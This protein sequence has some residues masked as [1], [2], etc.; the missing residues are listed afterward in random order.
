MIITTIGEV[1]KMLS[2]EVI[3][4]EDL[5]KKIK[6]VSIDSRK[7]EEGMIYV[8]LKGNR[9]DGHDFIDSVKEK[10]AALSL[11]DKENV[12]YPTGIPL[13]LVENT[14]E[15]LQKL[16]KEY[17][18]TLSCV[19]IGVTGSNG[20]TSCKDML[21]S[22]F[23]QEKK[24]QKTQGN[25]NNEIGL[26]LTILDFDA[27]IEVAILEMG[28]ENFHEIEQLCSIA[29]LDVA[30]ITTIGSAHMENLKDKFGIARA[31]LE[32]L[33][34]SKPD[35]LFIYNK[36]CPE[37]EAVMNTLEIDPRKEVVSFGE[38]GD[39]CL[40]S[41][42]SYEE[43]GI[44]FQTS[45]FKDIVHLKAFGDMQAMNALPAIYAARAL[46]I[47]KESILNGLKNLEMTKMRTHLI[48]IHPAKILDDSYKSNPESAKAALDTLMN[49]PG[50]RHVAILSDMLDLGPETSQL[51]EEIGKYAL[52]IG[53]DALYCVGELS[54]KT[55]E[56]FINGKW[57]PNKEELLCDSK[58]E[59]TRDC[60]ILVKGS[61]AMEMDTIVKA[62]QEVEK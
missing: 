44:S 17:L 37:I 45:E 43:N 57:Y 24:T 53:V 47:K 25:R 28:M 5:N 31:K 51:H 15:A 8:P 35:A 32:I 12:P 34:N 7:V 61:R 33:T 11:W 14:Q 42:I 56:G 29:P 49:I 62:L 2:S 39:I 16:A 9:V 18:H 52:E 21:Y 50:E 38:G 48:D 40:T 19:V 54:K 46:K 10:K 22:I 4:C 3:Q 6:G 26:P 59:R 55:A 30:I 60:V 27:D 58:Q 36:E 1:G 13:V 20:K 41:P 23:S